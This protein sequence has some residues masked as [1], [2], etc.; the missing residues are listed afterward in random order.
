MPRLASSA[1]LHPVRGFLDRRIAHTNSD[2]WVQVIHKRLFILPTA[3]GLGFL[4]LLLLMLLGA[5]NYNN[6]LAYAF[7]FLLSGLGLVSLYHTYRNLA[8][9]EVRCIRSR[10]AFAGEAARFELVLSNSRHFARYA[11][12][13][14]KDTEHLQ[15]VSVP[16]GQTAHLWV[17]RETRQRG[18]CHLGTL[19]LET[20]F[21]LGLFRAWS[22]L[23]L[24]QHA[25]VY[26]SPAREHRVHSQSLRHLSEEGDQGRGSDD[27][28]GFR[29]YHPGDSLHHVNWKAVAREQGWMIKEFGGDRVEERWFDWAQLPD[30]GPE[31]C[32]SQLCRWVVD[33]D[34]QQEHYGLRL[35]DQELGPAQGP[36]FRD[37]CLRALAAFATP[38]DRP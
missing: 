37:R 25:W 11:M 38:G 26:P 14:G 3:R 27:F 28:R 6:S 8:G 16:A 13:I 1:W 10:N 20:R 7:C 29:P 33:A 31:D 24:E 35:P 23:H 34:R 22:R 21:P 30:L 5:I 18:K 15:F 36:A 4:L 17:P 2:G 32:L 9:L 19:T 12:G